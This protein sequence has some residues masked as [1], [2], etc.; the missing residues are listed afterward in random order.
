[1][2]AGL[3]FDQAVAEYLSWLELDRHAGPRTVEENR[4]D[5]GRYA[6]FAGGCGLGQLDRAVLR[7]YQRHPARLR[8]GPQGAQRPP[9]VTT[10]ARRPV[11]LRSFLRFA[12]REA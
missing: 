8:T 4:A 11:A 10:R 5:L 6:W 1:M 9:A 7:A 3:P 2:S 12:A